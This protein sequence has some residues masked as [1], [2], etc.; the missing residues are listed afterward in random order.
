M[1]FGYINKTLNVSPPPEKPGRILKDLL[2]KESKFNS[3][4]FGSFNGTFITDKHFPEK[5]STEV[6]YINA[7][8]NILVLV[9]G[10]IY[11]KEEIITL[12]G[13]NIK[14]VEAAELIFLAYQKWGIYFAEK[15]NGDFAIVIHSKFL[16]QTI[17]IRDHLGI[18]PLVVSQS[19]NYIYF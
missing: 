2:W 3:Y 19:D 17:F 4:I 11:N 16:N 12:L 9:D 10:Y 1:L 5:K 7:D 15:L 8:E 6:S 18:R 13:K 14:E